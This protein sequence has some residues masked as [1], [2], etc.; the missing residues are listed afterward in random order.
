M[1]RKKYNGQLRDYSNVY[2]TKNCGTVEDVYS[3]VKMLE[4][5]HF[6]TG[7]DIKLDGG[8]TELFKI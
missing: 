7:M 2:P 4:N 8:M 3:V 5:N 1:I 6:M